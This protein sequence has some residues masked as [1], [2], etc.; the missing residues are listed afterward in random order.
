PKQLKLLAKAEY[1]WEGKKI[2]GSC[3]PLKTEHGWLTIYHAV[4]PDKLYRV[5]AMLLDL[6]DPTRVLCRTRDWLLQPEL[7]W[8]M[9]GH[10]N[11]VV[12]PC[13]NVIVGDTLFVY[14]GGGDVHCGLA[15]CSFS[16]LMDSLLAQPV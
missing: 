15:T 16:A 3:P 11:G 5:G 7:E 14:Y 9:K 8:E 12:F 10:Y 4:G 6:D 13:G 1:E 2:G